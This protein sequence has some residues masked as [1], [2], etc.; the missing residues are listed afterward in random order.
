MAQI[1][2]KQ[3]EAFV[4]VADLGTFRKAAARLNTT[5]PNISARISALEGQLGV[6]LMDRDAGSVRLTTKGENLLVRARAV[7]TGLDD[8]VSAAGDDTLFQGVLRLGVTEMIVHA[9]LGPYLKALNARFPNVMIDLTVDLS[10]NLSVALFD[11]AIDL[12]LQSGPF[13]RQISGSVPL[14]SYPMAWVAAPQLGLGNRKVTLKDIS[15]HPVL[16]H[17]RGT[18]PFEQLSDHITA[19]RNVPV[20]LVPSTNMAACLQMT[21][22]GLGVACLPRAMVRSHIGSG[23]LEELNYSWTPDK[24]TFC[25]RYDDEITPAYV[26][27]AAQI[28]AQVAADFEVG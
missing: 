10:S 20:R 19:T 2:L 26:G 24:L 16:T 9:W 14:G 22:D 1:T 7:L 27:Q 12:T 13:S 28:A 17:A 8:F 11:H 5:Q 23:E 6:R 21:V 3:I 18:L 15:A 4:Q 25:A